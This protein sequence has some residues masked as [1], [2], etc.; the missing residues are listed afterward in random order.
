MAMF[1]MLVVGASTS[2]LAFLVKPAL[3]EIFL[4]KNSEM[5]IWIPIAIVAV[6]L[7][8]GVCSYAQTVLMSFIGQ[9]IVADLRNDL[10]AKI[11]SQ[12]LAF[13]TRNPT[14]VLMSRIT[15]DIGYIQGAASEAVTSLLKDSF[16]LV[17]LIFVI[18]YR[19]W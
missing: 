5:L 10:Y 17:C 9:R 8:K 7:F 4:K 14:G 16:M 1:C 3:D 13:F 12:S 18:F 2:A 6:Y 15:N 19:D 11:Q